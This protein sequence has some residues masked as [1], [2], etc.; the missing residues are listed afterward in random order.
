MPDING[1]EPSAV[2]FSSDRNHKL[3]LLLI[4]VLEGQRDFHSVRWER[5]NNGEWIS[6]LEI[7]QAQ[8]QNGF[9]RRR[10]ISDLH[11][12]E[13][14]AGQAIVKVAEEDEEKVKDGFLTTRVIYSWR[15]WDLVHNL[16][17]CLIKVCD[18]PFDWLEASI[19]NG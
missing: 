2:A 12:F 3:T 4:D 8:F 19:K 1:L 17:V 7:T 5:D 13:P 6:W 9:D 14:A 10:W 18:N 15:V 11:S 16:E